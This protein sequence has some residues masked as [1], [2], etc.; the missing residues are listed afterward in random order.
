MTELHLHLDGSLRPETVSSLAVS[1]KLI[2]DEESI[3]ILS[4]LQV[5]DQ[6]TSLSDYLNCFDLPIR[7]LQTPDIIERVTF[8][9]A[10]DLAHEN[11]N[12]AELRFAPA[13]F[14]RKGF[15]QTEITQAAVRGAKKAMQQYPQIRIGLILC[16]MRGPHLEKENTE[17]IKTAAMLLGNIVCGV[18]LAGAEALF[19]TADYADLFR[20]ATAL[21]V[22]FTIHAGEAAGS[23]SIR[24]ALSFGA[25]R[26]G[27]GVRAIEDPS[28]VKEL[29]K[30]GTTL[31]V[32]LKSN[33][34]THCFASEKEHPIRRLFDAGVKVTLNSDNRTV[35]G[36]CL[37]NEIHIAKEMFGFTDEEILQMQEYAGEAAF[38]P[39][40]RP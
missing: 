37:A 11:I 17:T 21:D 12:Y 26:I 20:L 35:S 30:K 13:P 3:H 5:S 34:D 25:R 10:E 28:L 16:C 7:L 19:P 14:I 27:H 15:S 2:T 1:E 22:P 8:E 32:C 9:L 4:H 33:F 18:D 39:V 6:C 29:I 38:N 24:A 36:T 23:D 31:E 40:I